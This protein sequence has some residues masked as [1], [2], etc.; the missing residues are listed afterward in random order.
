MR[1]YPPHPFLDCCSLGKLSK[2]AV[3]TNY[4]IQFTEPTL[5]CFTIAKN[6]RNWKIIDSQYT[7]LYMDMK[8]NAS[9]S[10]IEFSSI[11]T[12]HDES[13]LVIHIETMH[14]DQGRLL[15]E[16]YGSNYW[17]LL[18]SSIYKVQNNLTTFS[19]CISLLTGG[20]Q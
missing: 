4:N 15:C 10:S 6:V 14:I 5:R 19:K 16:P 17:S 18:P 7:K 9:R 12:N 11:K 13:I 20:Q 1:T 2:M 3:Q 8:L